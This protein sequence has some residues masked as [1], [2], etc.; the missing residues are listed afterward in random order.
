MLVVDRTGI[1]L[2]QI[3]VIYGDT[4]VI[5]S[6]TI[7]GGSRS[8][9]KAGAAV[10]L[11]ADQ[12]VDQA[13]HLAAERLEAAVEDVILD[14]QQGG[15]F[16]VKGTPSISIDW[17]DVARLT[18]ERESPGLRCEVDVTGDPT[19]PFGAYV[20]VVEVDPETGRVTPLRMVTVDDAGRILNPLLAEGQV[21]G[22]TAQGIGQALYEQFVY[23]SDGN[24]LTSNFADYAIPCA[25]EMPPFESRFFETPAPSNV[26]GAK[27]LGESGTIGAPPAVQNAV[28]DAL[29]HLGVTHIDMPCTPERVWSAIT[30]AAEPASNR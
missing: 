8:V 4:D 24:P 20:A 21:H 11:A 5:P 13:R 2:E 1:P 7:T 10:A 29:R 25:A 23:D 3:D 15:Q 22:G 17:S 18:A 28:V 14:L 30:A 9:Q 19:F 26:L 27:G 12:L 16:H 6:G